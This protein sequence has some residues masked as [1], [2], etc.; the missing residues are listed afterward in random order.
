M[1]TFISILTNNVI[2]TAYGP[3]ALIAL[4]VAFVFYR[5]YKK[6][7]ERN[8][9]MTNKFIELSIAVKMTL[10]KIVEKINGTK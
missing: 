6:E 1:E 10:D 3:I 4:V 5:M 2:L 9:D 7:R 8:Q